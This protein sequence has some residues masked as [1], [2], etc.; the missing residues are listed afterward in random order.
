ML[1]LRWLDYIYF[2]WIH[3]AGELQC[4]VNHEILHST[5]SLIQYFSLE[6]FK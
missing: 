2:I 1:P 3:R 6:S 5:Y 4:Q